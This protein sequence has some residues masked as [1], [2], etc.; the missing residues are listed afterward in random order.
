MFSIEFFFAAYQIEDATLYIEIGVKELGQ[1]IEA[2]QYIGV[3]FSH[4]LFACYFSY[5]SV[6][7]LFCIS[8]FTIHIETLE[9]ACNYFLTGKL[10]Q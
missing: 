4:E 5:I 8:D 7:L 9:Q 3:F 1:N 10:F 2:K 6:V